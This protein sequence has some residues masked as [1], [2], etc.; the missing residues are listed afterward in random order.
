MTA[1]DK[2]SCAGGGGFQL[3]FR[4]QQVHSSDVVNSIK[5][6]LCC[7]FCGGPCISLAYIIIPTDAEDVMYSNHATAD[8]FFH[9]CLLEYEESMSLVLRVVCFTLQLY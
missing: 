1:R 6:M 3:C 7:V 4:G 2:G 9:V 5:C 8:V